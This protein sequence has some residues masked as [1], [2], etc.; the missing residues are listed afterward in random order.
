MGIDLLFDTNIL[1][2]L[3]KNEL[4]LK[5]IAKPGDRI[6][7]SAITLMEVKGFPFRS[8]AEESLIDKLCN[9]MILL[10]IEE[11]II[12]KVIEN[13]KKNMLKLPDAIILATAL[14]H[15]Q[16]LITRNTSDFSTTSPNI[17][18]RNPFFT[19]R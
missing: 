13:R 19:A 11:P 1:I 5:D 12:E 7:I 3:S 8:V 17:E 14:V 18:I 10:Y 16:I 9:Q 4:Q 15:K 2:Y 6:F